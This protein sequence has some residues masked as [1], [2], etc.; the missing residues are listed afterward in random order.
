MRA[1]PESTSSGH[2]FGDKGTTVFLMHKRAQH[3]LLR[4]PRF[5]QA[6]DDARHLRLVRRIGIGAR[7]RHQAA[8]CGIAVPWRGTG[9]AVVGRPRSQ[10]RKAAPAGGSQSIDRVREQDVPGHSSNKA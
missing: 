9:T 3:L 5:A 8:T 4:Q 6:F 2:L 1:L 10:Q 7:N